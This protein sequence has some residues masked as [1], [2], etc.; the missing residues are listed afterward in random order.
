MQTPTILIGAMSKITH[1][2]ELIQAEEIEAVVVSS[3]FDIP[4]IQY[5][6]C[7][8]WSRLPEPSELILVDSEWFLVN[9]RCFSAGMAD[10]VKRDSLVYHAPLFTLKPIPGAFDDDRFAFLCSRV[11]VP[12]FYRLLALLRWQ[13]IKLNRKVL[14]LA[15]MFG[16]LH[17][18]R[19]EALSWSKLS[20]PFIR[21]WKEPTPYSPFPTEYEQA[22]APTPTP[23]VALGKDA[24][25]AC[26]Y[27]KY[28]YGKQGINCA[29]HPPGW[30]DADNVCP[31]WDLK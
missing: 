18:E 28:Y 9:E 23:T 25:Q 6:R 19:Y 29:V 8:S 3:E 11:D 24:S 27:C 13:L 31:D 22:P 1:L 20:I 12:R 15:W 26:S 5:R 4:S 30:L 17:V 2:Q 21:H 16:F 7:F 10:N 14:L